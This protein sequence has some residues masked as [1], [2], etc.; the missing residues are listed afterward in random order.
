[1]AKINPMTKEELEAQRSI[2]SVYKKAI[3]H[4]LFEM[5]IPGDLEDTEWPNYFRGHVVD[6]ELNCALPENAELD[7]DFYTTEAGWFQAGWND[8]AGELKDKAAEV[9]GS[10]MKKTVIGPE[11]SMP[12]RTEI[13]FVTKEEVEK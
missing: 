11:R 4:A 12:P 6:I 1:M 2:P 9:I 10:Q 13:Y 3:E 7:N 5:S 8:I